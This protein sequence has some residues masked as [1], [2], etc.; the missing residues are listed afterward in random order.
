[1]TIITKAELHNLDGIMTLIQSVIGHMRSQGIDQWD[2]I[3]PNS[4]KIIEDITQQTGYIAIDAD[5]LVGYMVLNTIQS[6]EYASCS[7]TLDDKQP[8][9]IHRLCIHAQHQGKGFAVELVHWAE[10]F[11]IQ[12]NYRS[13]RLD[14]FIQ[15]PAALHLY[16]KL[17]YQ[18]IGNV[19][20][21]KGLFYCYEKVL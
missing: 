3:Y 5:Q 15:N 13:I 11:A 21:R 4:S 7:W 14:A 6:P 16:E 9:V 10:Q 12:E 20:F 1:M 17:G 19:N 2:E 18:R 8:L